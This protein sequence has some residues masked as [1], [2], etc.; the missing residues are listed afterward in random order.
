MT[1]KNKE[2]RKCKNAIQ[3]FLRNKNQFEGFNSFEDWYLSATEIGESKANREIEFLDAI[4]KYFELIF[5]KKD[6]FLS[7]S[8]LDEIIFSCIKSSCAE[9]FIQDVLE[10]IELHKIDSKSIVIFPLHNFGFQFLGFK[11]IFNQAQ[12]QLYFENFLISTQ[13][14]SFSRTVEIIDSF[15]KEHIAQN[16]DYSMLQHYYK[17]RSLKWLE[18]NP[19]LL[20]SFH[21]SQLNPSENLAV[22]LEKL[23][24]I[25]NQLY[26]LSILRSEHSELGKLFS[27]KQTNNW[28]TLDLKHFLTINGFNNNILCRPIHYRYDLLFND[29]HLN[30]DLLA[31]KGRITKPEN[32]S[33]TCLGTVYNGNKQYLLT[34][35]KTFSIY[36]KISNSLKYFRR[37][38]KSIN[39]ED[40]I[41]NINIAL[42]ALLLDNE[43]KKKEK[44]LE[45]L[46]KSLKYHR[47]KP[48]LIS[49]INKV[50]KERNNIV[51]NASPINNQIDFTI[52]Y[53]SYCKVTAY[54]VRNVS[55]IESEKSNR[56]SLF[57]NKK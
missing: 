21:F 7:S 9:N 43:G 40:K 56:M 16:I 10:Q 47:N 57:F 28:E 11:N 14:N 8:A 32:D 13:T 27:T 6:F 23:S 12:S 30:I 20:F 1:K 50:I 2:L 4:K 36:H 3:R 52:I 37:S 34:K 55:D 26:F 53:K 31:K 46:N 17:S 33:I 54:L 41:I 25:T 18:K 48:Y 49:E 38:V 24:H 42:E 19:F 29:M 51:H 45:R 15:S 35:D 39:T 22:I 44:I 5:R